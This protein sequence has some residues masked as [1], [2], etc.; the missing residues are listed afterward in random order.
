MSWGLVVVGI[1]GGLRAEGMWVVAVDVDRVLLWWCCFLVFSP[2]GSVVLGVGGGSD[3]GM[4][5]RVVGRGERRQCWWSWLGDAAP[6]VHSDAC[7]GLL[8]GRPWGSASGVPAPGLQK[9]RGPGFVRWVR[10]VNG[11]TVLSSVPWWHGAS[12]RTRP[13]KL[14]CELGMDRRPWDNLLI[15]LCNRGCDLL[16]LVFPCGLF[17]AGRCLSGVVSSGPS[18]FYDSNQEMTWQKG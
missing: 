9:S 12:S 14:Y 6:L 11:W 7:K 1:V 5:G 13:L 18:V 3:G 15:N 2:T 4:R 10:N 17:C 16:L 8:V